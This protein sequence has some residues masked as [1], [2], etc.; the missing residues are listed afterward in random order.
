MTTCT[1]SWRICRRSVSAALQRCAAWALSSLAIVGVLAAQDAKDS[2]TTYHGD[3]SG[4]R[5]SSLTQMTP[6]N[7]H[8]LTLAWAFATGQTQS[9]KA[10]PILA[11]GVIYISAPDHAWAIDA[12]SAHQ[13]W[14]YTYPANEGF[15]IGHR[16]MAIYNDSVF[17]T[18]PDSHLIA[19]DA[20]DGKV[21]WNVTIADAKKGYWSTNA[22]LL[23]RDHLLVGVS[24]DFDN[25]PGILTSVDP[26]TGKTQWTFYS[27]PPP[28]TA[29]N[30]SDG[31]T[32]GQMWMTGTYDP[33]SNLLFVG[34]GNPTPVLNGPVRAGDNRWTDSILALNPDTG[35][36]AWGFQATRH[37]T[38]DWDAAEVPVLVDGSFN[39]TPAKL[40]MQASRNGYF[41]VL[42][43]T[44]GRSLLTTTFATANWATGI[45]QD[46]RPIPNPAKEPARDGRL[47]APDES[48]G[49][50][51]RSPSFDPKTGVLVVSAHDAYG[52]YFFRSDHGAYGW[53]GADYGV[54]GKSILRA[55][56]YQTGKIRWSHDLGEGASA[57]GVLTTESGLTFTGDTAG[58]VIALRTS[59][60]ATLWHSG[61]GRVGNSPITYELDGRQYMLV[62]GGASLYAFA[63]PEHR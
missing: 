3:Y 37:D 5:H 50:N 54:F 14:H 61:I 13:L 43:R 46:G 2:W 28:G 62:A 9:I 32:G 12:R 29:G 25:L 20:K 6:A 58:N 15:H 17:L 39:G 31:A 11:N 4:R 59:D 49:T 45:D 19:L 47:V 18:T 21:K 41:Y 22:P 51:Y 23:I 1:T 48:G 53:A 38:H 55:I 7:V 8:Q 24:G 63:L 44:T 42:D 34:T 52:I 57:A 60:G 56:D 16:G 30:P 35:R 26:E 33:E 10:T 40:L 27:T 36:L